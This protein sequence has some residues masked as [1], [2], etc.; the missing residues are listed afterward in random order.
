MLCHALPC[1][2]LPCLAR[3]EPWFRSQPLPPHCPGQN[4]GVSKNDEGVSKQLEMV[5]P[6]FCQ[7]E[8]YAGGNTSTSPK[9]C[10]RHSLRSGF[11]YRCRVGFGHIIQ[12]GTSFF[13]FLRES[14]K[15]VNGHFRRVSRGL[16][17]L[18]SREGGSSLPSLPCEGAGKGPPV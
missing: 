4:E 18:L 6:R 10:L 5:S 15:A 8:G 11:G 3:Q 7:S 2:A 17:S 12:R 1:L 14:V 16:L 13:D 9:P